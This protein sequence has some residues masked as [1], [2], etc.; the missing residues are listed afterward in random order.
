MDPR[1]SGDIAV[2]VSGG[3]VESRIS[4]GRIASRAIIQI[5]ET[6][7]RIA[8]YCAGKGQSGIALLM[9]ASKKWRIT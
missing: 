7:R 3:W 5:W 1:C 9:Y 6:N 2:L 4:R 8:G